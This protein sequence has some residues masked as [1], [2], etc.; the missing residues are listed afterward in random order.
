MGSEMCIRDRPRGHAAMKRLMSWLAAQTESVPPLLMDELV[1]IH[2]YYTELCNR[3]KQQDD[4]LLRLVAEHPHGR[5]LKSIPGVGDM[6][7]SQCLADLGNASQFKNGRNLAAWLGLVPHQ[8][9]TG[10]KQTLL[11]ISKRGN[12]HLRTLF[13]H[14]ARA[15]L[16]RPDKTGAPFGD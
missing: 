7:A 15:I 14:G 9:S 11:G 16:A 12:K 10:G 4:K 8:H 5:L 6:T 3:I 1:G 2:E 13:I